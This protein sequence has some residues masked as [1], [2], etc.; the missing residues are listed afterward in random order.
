MFKSLDTYYEADI[1]IKE[2][3]IEKNDAKVSLNIEYDDYMSQYGDGSSHLAQDFGCSVE[4]DKIIAT[5]KAFVDSYQKM[6]DRYRA[7]LEEKQKFLD[8]YKK[9]LEIRIKEGLTRAKESME[10]SETEIRKEMKN[11]KIR[12]FTPKYDWDVNSVRRALFTE[13]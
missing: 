3:K 2:C 6:L 4:L 9:Q 13:D 11:Y 12:S 10:L 1:S 7:E 5:Q 8:N